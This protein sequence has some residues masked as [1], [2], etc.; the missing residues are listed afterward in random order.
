[1]KMEEVLEGEGGKEGGRGL[2]L[3]RLYIVASRM[4]LAAFLST[5]PFRAVP[6]RSPR[7]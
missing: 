3:M 1:M 7:R 5:A 2:T 4:E 6:I